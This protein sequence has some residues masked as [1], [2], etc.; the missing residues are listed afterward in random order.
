[1]H[2]I[3][4]KVEKQDAT[5]TTLKWVVGTCL[6]LLLMML[7]AFYASYLKSSDNLSSHQDRISANVEAVKTL[8]QTGMIDSAT[9]RATTKN[10]LDNIETDINDLKRKVDGGRR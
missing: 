4:M 7:S 1:M 5:Y 10:R 3:A 9:D 6:P 8:V 2:S